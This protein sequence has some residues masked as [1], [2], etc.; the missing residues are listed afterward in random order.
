MTQATAC[1]RW[2][3]LAI[4]EDRKISGSNCRAKLSS[5][6]LFASDG[7]ES[8]GRPKWRVIGRGMASMLIPAEP[9]THSFFTGNSRRWVVMES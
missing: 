6:S 5:S 8:K 7:G 4:A 1:G 9:L 3:K 2:Y